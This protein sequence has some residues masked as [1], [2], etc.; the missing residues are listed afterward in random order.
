MDESRSMPPRGNLRALRA[1]VYSYFSIEIPLN[2]SIIETYSPYNPLSQGANLKLIT[3]SIKG[4]FLQCRGGERTFGGEHLDTAV[5]T[6]RS[7]LYRYSS[8]PNTP[9]WN[10]GVVWL[11]MYLPSHIRISYHVIVIPGLQ[12]WS[13]H[14]LYLN[15]SYRHGFKIALHR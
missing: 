1:H 9:N 13:N 2:Y 8:K 12:K 4:F 10:P 3:S 6:P 15:Q 7:R 5:S 11:S 14:G